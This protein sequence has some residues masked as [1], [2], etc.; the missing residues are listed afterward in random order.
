[1]TPLYPLS[2]QNQPKSLPDGI[3]GPHRSP[4]FK[5]PFRRKTIAFPKTTSLSANHFSV[6]NFG[7]CGKEEEEGSVIM[8]SGLALG[9]GI[10]VASVGGS[11]GG[12]IE[13]HSQRP[14]V[15]E[16]KTNWPRI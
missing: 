13:N 3:F 8:G 16:K 6:K 9:K 4:I 14:E 12:E 2:P 7:F 1:M 10:P 11:W 5:N 15:A